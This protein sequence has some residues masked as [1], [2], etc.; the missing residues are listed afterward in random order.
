VTADASTHEPRALYVSAL[1]QQQAGTGTPESA[2]TLFDR[3]RAA[4]PEN[5]AGVAERAAWTALPLRAE[6]TERRGRRES[7]LDFIRSFPRSSHA[8]TCLQALGLEPAVEPDLL[9]GAATTLIRSAGEAKDAERL[10]ELVPV[11]L[12]LRLVVE[13]VTAADVLLALAPADPAALDTAA[14]ANFQAGH[15]ARAVALEQQALMLEPESLELSA[16][17]RRFTTQAPRL[18]EPED[19]ELFGASA[20]KPKDEFDETKKMIA[21]ALAASCEAKAGGTTGA[22]VRLTLDVA[23]PPRVVSF[24]PDSPKALHQ[25]LEAAG[26]KLPFA[27]HGKLVLDVRVRFGEAE[28]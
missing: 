22:W 17:L 10:L 18:P 26:A 5:S 16:N 9:R 8:V 21:T 13:A 1:E 27:L 15:R 7:L 12:S 11:L 6:V 14:E 20:K 28:R 19:P 4:D 3:A 24:D 23:K 2:L 25:C